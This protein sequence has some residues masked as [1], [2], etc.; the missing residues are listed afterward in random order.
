MYVCR[1]TC[2]CIYIYIYIYTYM[3]YIY[4]YIY[5][6]ASVASLF[7]IFQTLPVH[8][9]SCLAGQLGGHDTN[10][11]LCQIYRC[12]SFLFARKPYVV[13]VSIVVSVPPN[14]SYVAMHTVHAYY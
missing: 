10:Q 14:R 3:Y 7:L 2:V 13:F 6:Y 11:Q 5:I 1:Y 4:I 8:L 9:R 12:V